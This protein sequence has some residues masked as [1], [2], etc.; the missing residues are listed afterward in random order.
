ML[1][2][3]VVII[4]RRKKVP[5]GLTQFAFQRIAG[6]LSPYDF[7]KA[8][9]SGKDKFQAATMPKRICNPNSYYFR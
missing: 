5:H 6:S 8:R 7:M 9:V 4:I 2:Y 3:S 1:Q